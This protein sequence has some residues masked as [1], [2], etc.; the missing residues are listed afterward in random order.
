[1]SDHELRQ[2]TLTGYYYASLRMLRDLEAARHDLLQ[3]RAYIDDLAGKCADCTQRVVIERVAEL[4]AKLARVVAAQ[5]AIQKRLRDE[6][7]GCGGFAV[8]CDECSGCDAKA[9]M[10]AWDAAIREGE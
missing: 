6:A 2:T 3:A 8:T 10:L 1:M 7:F 5:K 4:E 9:V